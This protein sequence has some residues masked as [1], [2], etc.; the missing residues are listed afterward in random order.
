MHN[1]S[2]HITGHICFFS[3]LFFLFLSSPEI[4]TFLFILT[5]AIVVF[6]L[7]SRDFIFLVNLSADIVFL[8]LYWMNRTNFYLIQLSIF[9]GC[10]FIIFSLY[11]VL[12]TSFLAF[13]VII[14][15]FFSCIFYFCFVSYFFWQ[16]LFTGF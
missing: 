6:V 4:S 5:E 13:L 10:W 11:G 16:I 3:L 14:V 9:S 1:I 2:N 7:Q 15:S 12:P 8:V